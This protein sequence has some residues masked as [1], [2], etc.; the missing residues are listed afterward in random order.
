M[1]RRRLIT[2][3]AAVAALLALA[4]APS[5]QAAPRVVAL[6]PFTANTLAIV[7]VR[8]V[9]I[10]QTVGGNEH[11]SRRLQ[12][13]TRLKL[14]HPNGPSLELVAVLNPRLVLSGPVWKRGNAAIRSLG[15]AVAEVEPRRV[16][17][18][19]T[20]TERIG[21]LVGKP[22]TARALAD[23]QRSRI[24]YTRAQA[25]RHPRVLLVLGVGRASY[26]FLPNSW[27]GDVIRQA[28]GTLITGGLSA[29]GGY[30]RISDEFVIQANPDVIV[31]VPHGNPGD[32][33]RLTAYLRSN[34]AWRTTKA[35]RRGR[36]YVSTDNALLQPWTSPAQTIGD[37][38][39]QFLHNR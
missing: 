33:P 4:A 23:A 8:P 21:A 35:A 39:R 24:A 34:A 16:A 18:V 7:G 10:G 20:A 12:G 17:D 28:G 2:L 31:A 1:N 14:S 3:L 5:A 9:A 11:F 15:F 30:A 26:A 36:V 13:V 32:I 25:K 38:Q 22:L 6:T 37:V 29:S 27:G 19:P